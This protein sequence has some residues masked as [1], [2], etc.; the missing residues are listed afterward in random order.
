MNTLPFPIQQ[1]LILDATAWYS[2]FS[3]GDY[4]QLQEI[5]LKNTIT[6]MTEIEKIN[7]QYNKSTNF[8][9]NPNGQENEIIKLLE[10]WDNLNSLRIKAKTTA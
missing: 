7:M 2:K 8:G 1:T 3:T 10:E 6:R 5:G 4:Y 9:N